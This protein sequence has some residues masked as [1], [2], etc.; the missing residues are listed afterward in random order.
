[1]RTQNAQAAKQLEQAARREFLK[2]GYDKA[3]LR[4]I[5]LSCGMSTHMIYSRYGSKE[6][7]FD[8]L[9]K[10][11]ADDFM[12]LFKKLHTES[13]E[14]DRAEQ[15]KQATDTALN[16]IYEH[17]EDFKLIFC[18]SAGTKYEQYF[19]SLVEIEE[20]ALRNTIP[21]KNVSAWSRFFF[22]K[23]AAEESNDLYETVSRER[24][25]KDALEFMEMEKK[26]RLAGWSAVLPGEHNAG[27]KK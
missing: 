20:A 8:S 12:Q 2:A 7:L 19:D 1:M 6:G 11:T 21:F 15:S 26:F 27:K 3:S 16:F 22:H 10:D 24:T 13:G 14:P 23:K 18:R 25:K 9:V 5:A 17:F 4:A